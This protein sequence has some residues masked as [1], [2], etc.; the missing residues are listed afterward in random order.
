[1]TAKTITG[2]WEEICQRESELQGHQLR[3]TVLPEPQPEISKETTKYVTRMK[4]GRRKNIAAIRR[5]NASAHKICDL[6]LL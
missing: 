4:T 1:M 2:T 6:Y 3:V 5:R